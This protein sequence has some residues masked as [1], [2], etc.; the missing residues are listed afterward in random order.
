M[1]SRI[2]VGVRV[3][4]NFCLG[5]VF[6]RIFEKG[7]CFLENLRGGSV[8]SKIYEGG[9]C[10]RKGPGSVFSQGPGSGPGPGYTV[11]RLHCVFSC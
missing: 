5:S 6:S 7:P 2:F 11:R 8:F 3:F 9:Q 10:F 4:S 1:F